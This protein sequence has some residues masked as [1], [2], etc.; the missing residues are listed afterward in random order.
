MVI[1]IITAMV[2]TA[3]MMVMVMVRLMELVTWMHMG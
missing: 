3:I 2:V 1:T